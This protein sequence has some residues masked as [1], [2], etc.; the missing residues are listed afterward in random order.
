[1][2]EGLFLH[3]VF[4]LG[5]APTLYKMDGFSNHIIYI[6]GCRQSEKTAVISQGPG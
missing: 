3:K 2:C 4:T 5:F 1:M 6:L